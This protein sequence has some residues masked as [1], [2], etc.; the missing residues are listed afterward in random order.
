MNSQNFDSNYFENG[1]RYEVGPR[2][3]LHVGLTGFRLAPSALTLDDT[4]GSKMKV[5][6]LSSNMSKTATVTMLDS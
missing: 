3:H 5:K 6:L 4:E 1:D 2:E